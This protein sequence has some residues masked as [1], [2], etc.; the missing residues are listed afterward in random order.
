M[1]TTTD[2]KLAGPKTFRRASKKLMNRWGQNLQNVE[3]SMREM[4][5]PD[6]FSD[7]LKE[8]CAYW[9][10]TFD[11]S[12]FTEEE[13]FLLKVLVQVDQSGA[14]ALIVAYECENGDYRKLFIHGVKPH[15]YVGLKLFKDIWKKKVKEHSLAISSEDIDEIDLLPIEK[16][17]THSAWKDLDW[18]I[19]ESD[20][21]PLSERYYYFAKQTC[22]SANYGIECNKFIMN[23]LEKSG[24]KVVLTKEQGT[25]F[26]QTYRTLFPEIPERCSRIE[27]QVKST[28]VLYNLF[29]H[30]YQITDYEILQ[31]KIREFYAWSAQSTVGEITRIAFSSLQEYI[32][33]EMKQWDILN[34]N[35]DSYLSQAPLKEVKEAIIKKQEFMNQ[36][37]ISP[38]DGTHF[39]MR[40]EYKIGFNWSAKNANN[41]LGLREIKL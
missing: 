41:K 22:H 34:D 36:S 31:S 16:L 33:S 6:G 28:R 12:V 8:K 35:H 18:L 19:K 14:E 27:K 13:L 23:V 1:R 10:E 26:L 9:L 21:W 3:M 37:L 7:S 40:S 17:K 39:S 38:I 32:E 24:G 11:T 29:G 25:Y 15:V 5:I 4:Y 20:N 30:P 2:Y